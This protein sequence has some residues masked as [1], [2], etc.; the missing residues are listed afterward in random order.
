MG[1]EKTAQKRENVI[2]KGLA[3]AGTLESLPLLLTDI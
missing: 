3:S 1:I 2:L